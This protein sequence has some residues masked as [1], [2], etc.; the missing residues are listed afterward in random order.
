[1]DVDAAAGHGQDGGGLVFSIPPVIL[2]L[3]IEKLA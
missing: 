1:M 3:S 2:Q